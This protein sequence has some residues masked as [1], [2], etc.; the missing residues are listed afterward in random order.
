MNPLRRSATPEQEIIF[1][2]FFKRKILLN[3]SLI[4]Y[5]TTKLRK[6]F[7]VFLYKRLSSNYQMEE[8]VLVLINVGLK[9]SKLLI[10]V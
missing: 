10:L 5:E 7:V 8:N 4:S 2:G 9:Y 1:R 6:G 3:H